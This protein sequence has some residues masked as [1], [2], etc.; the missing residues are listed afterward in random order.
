M[1]E[2]VYEQIPTDFALPGPQTEIVEPKQDGLGTV[3]LQVLLMGQK[4]AAGSAAELTLKE[5]LASDAS[6]AAGWFGADS[7]LHQMVQRFKKINKYTK[8]YAMGIDDLVA[9]VARQLTYTVTG[10]ATASGTAKARIGDLTV[11]FGVNSGDTAIDVAAAI[12]AAM[13]AAQGMPTTQAVGAN[14]NEHVIT[15]TLRHKGEAGNDLVVSFEDLP[16]GIAIAVAQTVA[17]SGEPDVSE[18]TAAIAGQRFKRMVQPWSDA[19]NLAAIA[20]EL[21]TRWLAPGAIDGFVFIGK[22]GTHAQLVTYGN[23]GNHRFIGVVPTGKKVTLPYL[24]AAEVAAATAAK[25]D[26]TAP[27][28]GVTL[29]QTNPEAPEDRFD[30]PE[31]N[32][33]ILAG[34]SIDSVTPSGQVRIDA[35]VTMRTKNDQNATDYTWRYPQRIFTL[36]AIRDDLQI[37]AAQDWPGYK[38]IDDDFPTEDIGSRKLV[39]RKDYQSWVKVR[40][41]LWY[42]EGWI[43]NLPQFLADL[44]VV[45]NG[46]R[47]ETVIRADLVNGLRQQWFQIH[48]VI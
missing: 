32:S 30:D 13:D 29:K 11:R 18:I 45:K 23:S 20:S 12:V 24:H 40:A 15:A 21:E 25:A 35:I 48:P 19:T 6:D 14:P 4:L 34:V 31:R 42:R 10:P 5:C 2:I 26:Q 43:E 8:L 17:G 44:K 7:M 47:F 9:G 27:F 1:S 46:T 37:A 22:A 3:P 38:I 33:L 41:K 16:A 39:R 36:S 28:E